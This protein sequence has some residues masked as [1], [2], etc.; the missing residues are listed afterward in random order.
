[1]RYRPDVNQM[2]K[3]IAT[4]CGIALAATFTMSAAHPNIRPPKEHTTTHQLA[5]SRAAHEASDMNLASISKTNTFNI[6]SSIQSMQSDETAVLAQDMLKF[7]KKFIGTPY[8]FGSKGPKTFDCS[9]FTSYVFKNFGYPIASQS[10]LQYGLG[11]KV[12]RNN[13]VQAGDLV[14]FQGRSGRGGVGHVGIAISADP[15]SG[16]ITFIHASIRGVKIS[17]TTEPY[18]ASRYIGARRIL[19]E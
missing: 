18:Y 17:K 4:I 1:M 15:V 9:G 13:E 5:S 19:P 16:E 14:F 3:F 2:N 7:A 10:G 8:V 6:M 11:K 12:A